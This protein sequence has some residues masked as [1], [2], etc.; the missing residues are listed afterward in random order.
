MYTLKIFAVTRSDQTSIENA[1]A[2]S[3]NLAQFNGN[4]PM[5]R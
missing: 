4:I 2:I 3:R 1:S 5:W